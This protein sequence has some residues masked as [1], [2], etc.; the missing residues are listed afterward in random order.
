MRLSWIFPLPFVCMRNVMRNVALNGKR[1]FLNHR[2]E[3]YQSLMPPTHGSF[4]MFTG[5]LAYHHHRLF[6]P[7]CIF[8]LSRGRSV[9]PIFPFLQ[10]CKKNDICIVVEIDSNCRYARKTSYLGKVISRNLSITLNL[11]F[12]G[13]RPI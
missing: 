5:V 1:R 8:M 7:S 11:I 4:V 9:Q 2:C 6:L 12:D 13:P 10:I 3:V